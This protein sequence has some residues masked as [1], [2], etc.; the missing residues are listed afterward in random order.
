MKHPYFNQYKFKYLE[1]ND[2]DIIHEATLAWL[3]QLEFIKGE[4]LFLKEL[5][6]ENTLKLLAESCFEMAKHLATDLSKL[7]D[8]LPEII[9]SVQNHRNDIVV[10]IDKKD[11]FQKERAF[12]DGHLLLEIRIGSYLEK[13]H[14]LKDEI[15]TTMQNVFKKSKNRQLLKS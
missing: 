9:K 14:I 12:Q 3:S 15:F 8:Q 2:S 5:L 6:A 7:S 13:Y 4:Q 11:E 1:W 10:L